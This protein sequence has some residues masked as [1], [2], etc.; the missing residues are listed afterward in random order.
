MKYKDPQLLTSAQVG[1]LLG[2]R[3]WTVERLAKQ[4]RLP[5]PVVF[6]KEYRWL[7]Q[8]IVRLVNLLA[9]ERSSIPRHFTAPPKN[10]IGDKPLPDALEPFRDKLGLDCKLPA[11]YF[12]IHNNAVVYVG[13]SVEPVRRVQQHRE[14]TRLMAAKE[15]EYAF[16]LPTPIEE[17]FEAEKLFVALLNPVL[18]V[19]LKRHANQNVTAEELM[20]LAVKDSG[21]G[22]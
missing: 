13:I 17:I 3:H 19:S 4:G 10:P 9:K 15:F 7:H 16:F 5:S 11:V 6:D 2:I 8:D 12:L 18:N 20:R 14:G 22:K 1:E 21:H